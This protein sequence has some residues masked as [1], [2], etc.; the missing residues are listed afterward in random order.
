MKRREYFLFFCRER[1][2]L[3]KLKLEMRGG[4]LWQIL[5]CRCRVRLH[6]K[7]SVILVIAGGAALH[8]LHVDRVVVVVARRLY[9]VAAPPEQKYDQVHQE[10]YRELTSSSSSSLWKLWLQL[11]PRFQWQQTGS[12]LVRRAWR[13]VGYWLK[14]NQAFDHEQV[15]VHPGYIIILM[16][17]PMEIPLHCLVVGNVTQVRFLTSHFSSAGISGSIFISSATEIKKVVKFRKINNFISST[18]SN[19][20]HESRVH[21]F[22]FFREVV[23][24]GRPPFP[25]MTSMVELSSWSPVFV[26]VLLRC[27]VDGLDEAA[28]QSRDLWLQHP[29][30]ALLS[31]FLLE[32]TKTERPDFNWIRYRLTELVM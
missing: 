13:A 18:R 20:A 11:P 15:Q 30:R 32:R 27:H 12:L 2:R 29:D 9:G 1:K 16:Q 31:A 6:R 10:R 17:P 8:G 24:H 7:L 26:V 22:H 23:H 19:F 3:V 4:N 5:G 21:S 14:M 25:Q 28:L